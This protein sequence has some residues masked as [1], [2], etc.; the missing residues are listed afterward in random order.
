VFGKDGLEDVEKVLV[1]FEGGGFWRDCWAA[2]DREG[3]VG[4]IRRE[5]G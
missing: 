3:L 2:T 1:F 4:W 5:V